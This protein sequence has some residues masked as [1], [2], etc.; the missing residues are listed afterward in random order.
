M[1]HIPPKAGCE[2]FRS[3]S[4][5]QHRRGKL[6]SKPPHQTARFGEVKLGASAFA[7]AEPCL[8]VPDP[9][10]FW[11]NPLIVGDT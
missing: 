5:G 11:R 9:H 10:R 7:F 2:A 1:L 3:D 6:A 8:G 4:N